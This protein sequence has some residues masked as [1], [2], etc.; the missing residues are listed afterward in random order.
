MANSQYKAI[1][2]DINQERKEFYRNGKAALYTDCGMTYTRFIPE[3]QKWVAFRNPKKHFH[4]EF[5][6]YC[7]FYGERIDKPSVRDFCEFHYFDFSM[8]EN[9]CEFCPDGDA[10]TKYFQDERL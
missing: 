3:F 2:K 8:L 10:L 6:D 4:K 1:I 7:E 5:R 9:S